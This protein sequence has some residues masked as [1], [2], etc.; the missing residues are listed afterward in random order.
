[1]YDNPSD[2]IAFEVGKS[3]DHHLKGINAFRDKYKQFS[4]RCYMVSA[5]SQT[6]ALPGDTKDGIGRIPLDLFLVAVSGCI[7]S[8]LAA[9]LGNA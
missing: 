1:V 5:R 6:A 8:A 7:S 4:D 3:S 9:R 2:P